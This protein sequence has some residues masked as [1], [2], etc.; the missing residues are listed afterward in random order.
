MDLTKTDGETTLDEIKR[1]MHE[2]L[3]AYFEQLTLLADGHEEEYKGKGYT[4]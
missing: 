1:G 3:E 4:I 2:S